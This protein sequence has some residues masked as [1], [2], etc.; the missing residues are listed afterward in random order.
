M[1]K[2]KTIREGVREFLPK[3]G[4]LSDEAA[5][6]LIAS[7]T[8]AFV[9]N[10]T[11]WMAAALVSAKSYEGKRAATENLQVEIKEDHPS[12]LERFA[13]G[14]GVLTERCHFDFVELDVTLIRNMVAK[15]QG[16]DNLMLIMLLEQASAEFI[17][18]L[19]DLGKQLR[20]VDLRYTHVH[21]EVDW[22]HAEDFA[23]AV[24]AEQT[25]YEPSDTAQREKL[26][27]DLVLRLL[28]RIFCEIPAIYLK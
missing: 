7:Y 15:L 19:E 3:P 14:C 23:E 11:T 27:T 13:R 17:P 1:N 2:T 16:L 28:K 26:V 5:R 4:S 24:E 20:G 6:L 18:V 25:Y 8:A 22:V 21:G 9:G 12:M 10:F